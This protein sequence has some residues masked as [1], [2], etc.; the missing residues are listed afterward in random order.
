M[1]SE[2]SERAIGQLP[3]SI[4]TS[5]ALESAFG[6][7]PDIKVSAAPILSYNEMWINLKTLFRNFEG[8]LQKNAT[9]SI[10]ETAEGMLEEI[11]KI[12]ELVSEYTNGKTKVIFYATNYSG[13]EAAYKHAQIRGD[14]TLLQKENTDRYTKAVGYVL[15]SHK[16]DPDFRV[17]DRKLKGDNL[18]KVLILTHIPYDLVSHKL[19]T[20][21]VLLES[22]TGK[23]KNKS[24]WYTKYLNG[25]D[26]AIIPFRE[27]LLQ[28]FGDKETFKPMNIDFR[29]SVIAVAEKYK[30][31][32][33]TTTDKIKYGINTM[34][35]P[36]AK[37]V[38][39][40]ILIH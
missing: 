22:H 31:S 14:T 5:L 33:A 8:S 25:N 17:F 11:D 18:P 1:V 36:Y 35:N 40:S 26:L 7:H 24:L 34:L 32:S 6:I 12:K 3:L 10:L 13:M 16:D 28:V 37:Q 29:N 21:L 23:I 20:E 9:V 19:F 4:A 27:D 39:N 30:W 2:I 15:K 38:L